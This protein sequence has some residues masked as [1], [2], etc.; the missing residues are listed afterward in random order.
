MNK[1]G[2]AAT[3]ILY[4]IL[5]LFILLMSSILMMLYSRNNLLHKIQS[6]VKG[7]LSSIYPV[8]ENGTPV[9]FNP[10]TGKLCS[11]YISTNS[12]NR[13]NNGCMK[14]Y[15]FNDN[16]AS[17]NVNMILDHNTTARIAWDSTGSGVMKEV[18]NALAS[19]IA[20]WNPSIQ[21]TARLIDAFEVAQITGKQ[22][23]NG[24]SGKWFY[25]DSNTNTPNP[26]VTGQGTS[27]Y[28]W[29]YDYIGVDCINKGCNFIDASVPGYWTSTLVSNR[30]GFAWRIAGGSY[31]GDA[32]GKRDD[33]G[34]VRPVITIDKS[35]IVN[36]ES[37]LIIN[38]DLLKNDNTNFSQL[39]YG[40]DS[41]GGYLSYTATGNADF[42]TNPINDEYIAI[43]TTKAYTLSMD[44]KSNNP[45]SK[46][47]LGLIEYDI[48]KNPILSTHVMYIDGSLT[49]LTQDLNDGDTVMHLNDV[50]GF[51]VSSSTRNYQRGFIFWDYADTTGYAYPE[52]TY[53]RNYM[54]PWYTYTGIH[55][56]NNT[57][58]LEK[59]WALGFKP[60]GTKLSQSSSGGTYNYSLVAGT[61]IPSEWTTYTTSIKDI[62]TNGSV[63]HSK[64]RAGTKYVKLLLMVSNSQNENTTFSIRNMSL[65]EVET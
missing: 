35:L 44:I 64:F 13:Y 1:K 32:D 9:Y 62:T 47:Y 58:T 25:L 50:S 38:G 49:Y 27:K 14:W 6:E 61:V 24:N 37:N 51:K 48:D 46:Y 29:L 36:N 3:G 20:G 30:S 21:S 59:P 52:L 53:S 19:D 60:K 23:F 28:A 65:I 5:V 4:T 2:F 33:V 43:D 31:V 54:Y 41:D 42:I 45:N 12:L 22:D 40:I 11:E 18:A 39:T 15:I 17:S 55:T 26:N 57:I 7:E 10:V 56:S 34:G 8:Y 63:D 16:S